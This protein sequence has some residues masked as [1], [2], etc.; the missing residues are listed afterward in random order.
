MYFSRQV[1]RSMQFHVSECLVIPCLLEKVVKL[2]HATNWFNSK[3]MKV[4]DGPSHSLDLNPIEHLWKELDRRISDIKVNNSKFSNIAGQNY[5]EVRR[6]DDFST[7][8]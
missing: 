1:V 6:V 7:R 4:L 3:K 2:D 8:Y 5:A